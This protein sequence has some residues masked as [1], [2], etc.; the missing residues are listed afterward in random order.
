MKILLRFIFHD[1]LPSL[2]PRSIIT[3]YW[4]FAVFRAVIAARRYSIRCAILFRYLLR[5]YAILRLRHHYPSYTPP[6]RLPVD[7]LRRLFSDID[8]RYYY[9]YADAAVALPLFTS[10]SSLY[11]KIRHEHHAMQKSPATLLLLPP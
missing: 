6:Y 7:T 1:D 8:I 3:P 5:Y 2:R 9:A 10:C 4:F 11:E